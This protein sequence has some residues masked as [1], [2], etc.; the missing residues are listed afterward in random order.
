MMAVAKNESWYGNYVGLSVNEAEAAAKKMC[1]AFSKVV[2][3]AMDAHGIEIGD[4]VL[5][6]PNVNGNEVTF[7]VYL[8]HKDVIRESLVESEFIDYQP[9]DM[10]EEF[11][12]GWHAKR[13]VF[14]HRIDA[15][16]HA[17]A[18]DWI[19]EHFLEDAIQAAKAVA[20]EG[21]DIILTI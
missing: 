13:Q 15:K 18:T 11:N 1:A 10:I 21:A 2:Q 17:S 3:E 12:F 8:P 20:P 16:W 6:K 5:G 9:V 7:E 14:N 19:G 4:A